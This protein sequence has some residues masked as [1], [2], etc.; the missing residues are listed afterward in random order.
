[1]M[2]AKICYWFLESYED[3]Y[4]IIGGVYLSACRVSRGLLGGI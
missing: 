4:A 2:P 3:P 1:M